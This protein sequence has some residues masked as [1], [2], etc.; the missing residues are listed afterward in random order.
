[1]ASNQ[2]KITLPDNSSKEVE[3]GIS[4]KD[5]IKTHIGEGL[6]R[7]AIAV[8]INDNL[9]DITTP[10]T[11]SCKFTVH[12]F[13]DAKGKEVFWHSSAHIM[14]IAVMRLFP[15][16]KLTIG[17]AI[18][19]G[20]YYDFQTEK[21]FSPED[22]AKIEAEMQNVI[23]EDKPFMREPISVDEARKQFSDNP[24][25]LELIEEFAKENSQLT[26]YRTGD[27]FDLCRGPHVENAGKIK[28]IKI[29]KISGAYWRADAKNPQL[30]RVYGVSFPN[31]DDLKTHLDNLEQA[32]ARDHRKL[33]KE[34][35][36]VMFHEYAPGMPF[37]LTKGT[38]IYNT[39]VDFI[40]QEYKKRGYQEVITPQMF[41]KK[42]WE[43]SG[44]WE[45]YKDDM[46]VLNVD[47]MEASLKPMN[48]PSHCLIYANSA[49]SYRDLPLRIADFCNLHRNE[50]SGA[51]SGM[52]RVRKF[53]Q[54]DAHIFCTMEQIESE[55]LGVLQFIKYVWEEIFGFKL[56][57]S[58]STRPEKKY[59]GT[60]EL[61]I[62]AE[63]M[64][65][66]AMK[67]AGIEY[68]IKAGDG[69]FYGPKIDIDMED[70]L[71]RKWQCPTCQL[72][73]NL[74]KRFE[75][76]Y[77]GGDGQK[78]MPVMIHR[79]VLGSLERCFAML[80]ENYAG[81]F[82]LWLS[83]VQIK[84][85]PIADR[86]N[87]YVYALKKQF[88]EAGLRAEVDDRGLTT[89]NKVRQA[90]EE[91]VNYI[92]VVGDQEVKNKTANVRTRNN[93]VLGEKSILELI[94]EL[95][96]QVSKFK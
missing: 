6:A 74:P 73:F 29:T 59:L 63:G 28:A 57:Y 26:I 15:K 44:H 17:P 7:A 38:V 58:L 21:T 34:H 60:P 75:L 51:L 2:I 33:A 42:L 13:K 45:H 22:I 27:F 47:G 89:S 96:T 23:K 64:L 20:F 95:K 18:E 36:L 93:E 66:N 67:K 61:W 9:S 56:A 71:G 65:A 79:A 83:P 94:T 16:T 31:K 53:A 84:L 77:E 88:I 39:L 85:L 62:Q 50:L 91:Q 68:N 14:A 86:H 40:R 69:A 5:F 4:A 78:H 90:Q 32:R 46:F 72:D 81:K 11:Q 35:N 30:Q 3:A 25:K 55:V 41:N 12:T 10:L 24:F 52:T 43:T 37:F 87:E 1:M 54:D 8:S 19:D 70:A 92:L 76:E 48:C 82:P 80:V 49:K